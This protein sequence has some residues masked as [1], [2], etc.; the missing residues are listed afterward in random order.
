MFYSIVRRFRTLRGNLRFLLSLVKPHPTLRELARYPEVRDKTTLRIPTPPLSSHVSFGVV[1]E[2]SPLNQSFDSNRQTECFQTTRSLR[3]VKHRSVH[4]YSV[5]VTIPTQQY[6]RESPCDEAARQTLLFQ[7]LPLS[8]ASRHRDLNG[9]V[10]HMIGHAS[11]MPF[12]ALASES[13]LQMSG[14]LGSQLDTLSPKYFDLVDSEDI[15]QLRISDDIPNV[16][17]PPIRTFATLSEPSRS[18]A[19]SLPSVVLT[20]PTPNEPSSPVFVPRTPISVSRFVSASSMSTSS[21][22]TPMSRPF[23]VPSL[24][25]CEGCGLTAFE[26]GEQ[27][28]ECDNQWLACKIWYRANDGGRRQHLTEPYIR[29]GE[30]TARN[31]ALHEFLGVPG[32]N[33]ETVGLG[34]QVTPEE[35]LSI[36]RWR[37]FLHFLPGGDKVVK[38][39]GPSHTE[40]YDSDNSS[41]HNFLACSLATTISVMKHAWKVGRTHLVSHLSRRRKSRFH[42]SPIQGGNLLHNSKA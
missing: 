32:G 12:A 19:L 34:F 25:K 15:P 27:C 23:P 31:R 36:A 40:E 37:R 42:V 21:P 24:P 26:T 4:T 17:R 7:D 39:A 3:R 2:D 33:L 35:P 8:C 5:R 18:R 30:S 28:S 41:A 9:Y 38:D 6:V 14:L 10:E 11:S 16:Q 22:L 20:C 13:S 29:P 1:N